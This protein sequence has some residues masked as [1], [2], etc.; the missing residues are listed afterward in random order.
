MHISLC[1]IKLSGELHFVHIVD[2]IQ[3]THPAIVLQDLH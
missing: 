2:D 3:L 1:R